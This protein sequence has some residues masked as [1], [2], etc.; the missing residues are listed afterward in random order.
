VGAADWVGVGI[1][2]RL[3]HVCAMS[4]DRY[5][6]DED[7]PSNA[8]VC[9]YGVWDALEDD[10][11]RLG[12]EYGYGLTLREARWMMQMLNGHDPTRRRGTRADAG[13]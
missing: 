11:A 4:S 10:Y 8:T 12:D 7:A 2:R 1:N 3:A 9:H 6:L 13:P 5:R